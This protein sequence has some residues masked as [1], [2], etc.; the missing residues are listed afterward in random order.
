MPSVCPFCHE[1]IAA[2]QPIELLK[3]ARYSES[4]LVAVEQAAHL[5]CYVFAGQTLADLA[6][7]DAVKRGLSE[8]LH[9]PDNMRIA[10]NGTI[11]SYGEP[12]GRWLGDDQIEWGR[13]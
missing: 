5:G 6:F 13:P 7:S 12:I 11:L 3:T 9:D 10:R 4:G 2:D 8:K 1:P